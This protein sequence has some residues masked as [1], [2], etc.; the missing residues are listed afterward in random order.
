MEI[1]HIRRCALGAASVIALATA[2]GIA[3]G[4]SAQETDARQATN[5]DTTVNEVVVVGSRA[6][7]QSAI[8]RKKRAKTPTD[9]IVADDVGSFPD[10]NVNEAIS[11]IAGT[12]LGRNDFGE[13]ESVT[14]RGN[15][16]DLTRV[17]LDGLGVQSTNGLALNADSARSADMRELPADLI[18][19]VDVIKG[20]TADMTEGSL[21]GTIKIQ[22][23]SGLL[24]Y[25]MELVRGPNLA[26]LVQ[27]E[28]PLSVPRVIRL[29]REA[30][31]ALSQA[32]ALGLVHRD[33]KPENMLIA[34]GGGL[35]IT[36]FGLALALRGGRFGGATSQSGTPQFA[37]PEQLLGEKV[38]QRSDLYSLSAVAYYALLGH[39][40]FEGVTPEQVLA[41]QTTDQFPDLRTA[42]PDVG[43]GLANVLQRA[44]Q[45]AVDR[46]YAT[47][48]DFLQVLN[49]VTRRGRLE[50]A[51]DVLRWRL[52]SL[53]PGSS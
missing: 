49:R 18:K 33:I 11:R 2:L 38:D 28:G 19:S 37:S 1:V 34:P 52:G 43:P 22:T 7:Q 13:G 51:V 32:H 21:G 25:T 12:A 29:L 26:Q 36:D 45:S 6:S 15:G 42:V 10:R 48:T 16:P 4:A 53:W 44:L 40:P 17:E 27:R 30:L 8:E 14:V 39:P 9:S 24:W 46:R 20:S 47:A 41:R 23:R 35:K 3:S 31:S 50:R 5:D